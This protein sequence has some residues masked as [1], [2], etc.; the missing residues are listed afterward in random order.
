MT[1]DLEILTT[2]EKDQSDN[3]KDSFSV[4][5]DKLDTWQ[6]FFLIEIS[7]IKAEIKNKSLQKSL[8]FIRKPFQN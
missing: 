1:I 3:P 7:D 8:S 6:N 2:I 4:S 5:A